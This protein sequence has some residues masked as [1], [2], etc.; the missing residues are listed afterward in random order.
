LVALT[1]L[2]GIARVVR[3]VLRL[4]REEVFLLRLMPVVL[5]FER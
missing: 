5:F 1:L 2:R 3:D 4:A